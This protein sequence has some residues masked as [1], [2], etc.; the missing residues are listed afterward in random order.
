[1]SKTFSEKI[2]KISMSVFPRLIFCFI[3]F[4]GVSQRWEFKNTT[5]CVL[6][7][8]SCRKV[9]T[10]KSTKKNKTD[11]FSIFFITFWAFLR[12]GS[13]KTRQNNLEK[14]LISPGTFF[15]FGPRGPRN[16]PTTNHVNTSTWRSSAKHHCF[17][18]A[19]CSCPFALPLPTICL[20]F[21][22]YLALGIRHSVCLPTSY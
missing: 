3:A 2:V 16:Q 19:P 22:I 10:K 11:L 12:E 15:F 1:M 4:S 17:W 20:L 9:F 5:K 21:A 13:S 8:G 14:K 6:Q 18:G 7:K